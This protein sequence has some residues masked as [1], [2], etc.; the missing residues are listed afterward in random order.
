[1]LALLVPSLS[2]AEAPRGPAAIVMAGPSC[3]DAAL[4][5]AVEAELRKGGVAALPHARVAVALARTRAARALDAARRLYTRTDFAGCIALLSITEQE[6]GRSLADEDAALQRAHALLAQVNLWLGVCQWAAG[7]PQTAATAFVRSAQLPTRP[8]PDPRLLP[9]ELV[10]A[11]R[12]A[13]SAPRPETSC[14][15]EP[16]LRGEQLLVDGREPV[17]EGQRFRTSAGTHYLTIRVRCSDGAGDCTALQRRIGAEGM[18]SLRLEA[19]TLRCRVQ[20][21][22]IPAPSR[23]TCAASSEASAPALVAALTR[24]SGAGFALIAA[25]D[26]GKIALRLL[27]AGGEG[28]SRQLVSELEG[29]APRAALE[30]NLPLVLGAR[31]AAPVRRPERKAWYERWWV[32]TVAGAVMAGTAT[33][34]SVAATRSGTKEYR[35]VF[36]P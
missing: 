28:F 16:P 18:R 7:D 29:E 27:R 9:P 15:V 4:A 6:L 26:D 11:H 36:R 8:A 30:R 20:V 12:I 13:V 1:M 21:P 3:P 22:S 5:G 31:P 33:A 25:V 14:E 32:W 2:R 24:E 23:V 35:I 34:I 17:V 10:E 19:G